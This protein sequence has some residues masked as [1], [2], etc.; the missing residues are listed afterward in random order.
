MST[1]HNII[2]FLLLLLLIS[3]PQT[4]FC[5][6]TT[7]SPP[8]VC[9]VGSGIAGSS[10]A[11]FLRRYSTQ[12]LSDGIQI[13]IFERS[14]V[15]G[16]RM[17][18]VSVAGDTFEAGA[19]ILHSKNY[20]AVNFTQLLGLKMKRPPKSEDSMSIGIW[21]G[22]KFVFRTLQVNSKSPLVQKIV[23]FA[24]SI[25]LFIRYG[26]SL[27]K[28]ERFVESAV[29]RF[30]KYYEDF[31][32]RPVFETVEEMLKWAGLFNLTTR[33]LQDELIDAKL[34]VSLIDELVTVITRINYGQSVSISGLAG[35][36]SLAGSGGGLWAV[37]GGN[38]QMAAG[39]INHSDVL[40][41]LNEEIKSIS[42]Q[43]KFYEL[44]STMGN[45]YLCEV[46]VV[47]TPLEEVN[48][49]F[50]PLVSVPDRKL[51]HT[52]VTFVRGLL[53]PVY[54]G[55]QAVTDIPQLVGTMEDPN[56][57][58][59]SISILK[60]YNE[61]DITYKLF[62]RK[63]MT[64]A[65]LDNIFSMRKDTI[66]I[67]WGAY[68]FYRAPEVFAPFIL[69]GQHL[70]YVNTFENAASTMETSAVAA[71]NVARLILS[72]YFSEASLSS[73]KLRTSAE[74]VLHVDL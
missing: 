57:P 41:H 62:S 69:D 32:A 29:D 38:W 15:V 35:A 43:E 19:S 71:E 24:N 28:M 64:D 14:G 11:H 9:I 8:T 44:N 48:I 72:R 13:R 22:N 63:P 25:Y 30:L 4:L 6:S 56:L 45:S 37:E 27:L 59:S 23:S 5:V 39:L 7:N 2:T 18:T 12:A 60:Q 68:P 65:L 40:L 52:H 16:G 3:S 10:V 1:K 36:V 51:Q 33:T 34:S 42:Y 66:R 47:A 61:K 67:D 26:S 53:N 74:E 49:H 55:L 73:S 21:D 17:A 50:M 46:T 54:F 70:Y 58:F 20:H 31:D